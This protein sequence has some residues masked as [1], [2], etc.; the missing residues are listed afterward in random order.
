MKSGFITGVCGHAW[1]TV[2][3]QP[4]LTIAA[5]RV[6]AFIEATR[7]ELVELCRML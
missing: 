7:A 4:A 6:E 1:E 3:V 5:D 2:R